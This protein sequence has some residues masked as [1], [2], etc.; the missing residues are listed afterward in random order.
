MDNIIFCDDDIVV[1]DKP[2]G[3]Y[4]HP[5][6]VSDYPIPYNQILM[7]RLRDHY[8]RKVFPVHRL[9]V[10]TSGVLLFAW[11]SESASFLQKNW[12]LKTFKKQYR[13]VCRGWLNEE[14]GVINMPLESNGDGA[15]QEAITHYK[16]IAQTELPFPVGKRF[17]SARY[18]L[19][20]L[21]LETGRWHQIRR[22]LNRI[23]HPLIGDGTHGD[24]HHNR[25]FREKLQLAGLCLRSQRLEI[26]HPK[27]EAPLVFNAPAT[28]KWKKIDLLF[29]DFDAFSKQI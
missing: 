19:L 11:N 12:T 26:I 28:E 22:H 4:V 5:P 13:A 17:P 20:E 21:S 24:S 3:Y 16:K 6:E 1:I 2:P 10:A 8:K 18:S 29:S 23:S 9:D 15:L 7:Y 27:T 25:F 14:A